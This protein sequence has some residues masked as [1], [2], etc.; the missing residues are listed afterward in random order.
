MPAIATMK[1]HVN[2]V[3]EGGLKQ[4]VAYD[5][6][7]LDMDRDD[8]RLVEPFEVDAVITKADRELLVSAV[9]HCPVQTTC[10]RCLVEFTLTL[11]PEALFS[12]TVQPTDVV[13]IT[14]D[15]RQEVILAY[16]MRPLCRLDC[17]GLCRTC[18]QNLNE[19]MCRHQASQPR[20]GASRGGSIVV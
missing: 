19:R 15:V 11:T 1:I 4:H 2:R 5:P 20:E 17:K 12:Y 13:D 7:V 16:P 18:G 3:P 14:E 10:A 6:T 9:I 8:V